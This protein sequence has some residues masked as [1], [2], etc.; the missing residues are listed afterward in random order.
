MEK[1][2]FNASKKNPTKTSSKTTESKIPRPNEEKLED[3]EVVR[4]KFKTWSKNYVE[5]LYF[6]EKEKTASPFEDPAEEKMTELLP[7]TE[8][9]ITKEK[10]ELTQIFFDELIDFSNRI[11]F[12]DGFTEEK[13][14]NFF[15]R[16]YEIFFNRSPNLLE[17]FNG[18]F[19]KKI[20]I[21]SRINETYGLRGI[22]DNTGEIAYDLSYCSED[23]VSDLLNEI[24]KMS[25]S[26]TLS[27]L[28]Q[29][30]QSARRALGDGTWAHLAF[31]RIVFILKSLHKTTQFPIISF[32]CEFELSK[33][34]T[35]AS[36]E[37][38]DLPRENEMGDDFGKKIQQSL[39][40]E[41]TEFFLNNR[42]HPQLEEVGFSNVSSDYGI[43][44]NKGSLTPFALIERTEDSTKEISVP[45][46]DNDQ[47]SRL[48]QI[49]RE[50]S[51]GQTGEQVYYDMADILYYF[52]EQGVGPREIFPSVPEE[53]LA[54]CIGLRKEAGVLQKESDN[55]KSSTM[56]EIEKENLEKSHALFS[57]AEKN[58]NRIF[59]G[60]FENY[61]KKY[62]ENKE[63]KYEDGMWQMIENVGVVARARKKYPKIESKLTP[64]ELKISEEMEEKMEEL[65]NFH[66]QNW[67]SMWTRI[68]D[69]SAE[70]DSSMAEKI[71]ELGS[72]SRE[73]KREELVSYTKKV[74]EENN[75]TKKTHKLISYDGLTV[76]KQFNPLGNEDFSH[77]VKF[78]HSPEVRL[79][80][81]KRL[82]IKIESL[83]LREQIHL[84][85]FLAESNNETYT[86]IEK[87]LHKNKT[88]SQ[89]ILRSFLSL[90]GNTEM[91]NIILDMCEKLPSKAIQKIF[92]K[93][94]E[95][96]D[97][98][99]EVE[100]FVYKAFNDTTSESVLSAKESLFRRAK[101]LLASY[102]DQIDSGKKID[103]EK[104]SS[105]LENIKSEILLFAS[106]FKSATKNGEIVF[107]KIPGIETST[108]DPT[109]IRDE[110][111]K[112]MERIFVANRPKYSSELLKHTL[113][114]FKS[115]LDSHDKE[116]HL[117]KFD[118][119]IISF[120]RFDKLPDGN[121]YAGSLNVRP[122]ARGSSIGSVILHQ[123]LDEKALQH[124]V[125]AVVYSKNPM[126][127]HYTADFGFEIVEE[128]PNFENTGEL[129]YKI[130]R[131]KN[132]PGLKAA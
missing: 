112:E 98:T 110:D 51:K 71:K 78:L 65:R 107:D 95:I 32:A 53:I 11:I 103:A 108:V 68:E 22:P 122:E 25:T 9:L 84:L 66:S 13:R 64:E 114:E 69:K 75:E 40:V 59:V 70:I 89:N 28:K 74:I 76:Q 100:T 1:S 34:A 7:E 6:S 85:R 72:T 61:G 120:L 60:K 87:I 73:L 20:L 94:N 77:L 19:A 118:G 82:G 116:F 119:K 88:D 31:E 12:Q 123:I 41:T 97:L 111:K 102:K 128:L 125:E 46:L 91:G 117:L 47:L 92:K 29:L 33:I 48:A 83:S 101:D 93:Y 115:A 10:A 16:L 39:A 105:E 99:N 79:Y 57:F 124:D 21:S 35:Y 45:R 50:I 126:L 42:T 127:K 81:N 62:L 86:R 130:I 55:L 14:K 121:L 113:E 52:A 67:N 38:E 90:S 96:V 58:F 106:S 17:N 54:K 4:E 26:E 49:T 132:Q 131:R 23:T 44:L 37:M 5:G 43:I 56:K 3:F 15:G 36:E 129:Y 27:V 80:I 24:K 18:N 30:S 104:V 2:Q 8:G 63:K 109:A